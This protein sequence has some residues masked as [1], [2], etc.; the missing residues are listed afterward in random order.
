MSSDGTPDGQLSVVKP[1]AVYKWEIDNFSVDNWETGQEVVSPVIVIN[2]TK[3]M[4][5]L[6][7]KGI[8]E[9]HNKDVSI[10]LRSLNESDVEIKFYFSILDE[11]N[12]M[13]LISGS[14]WEFTQ[15]YED[16]GLYGFIRQALLMKHKYDMLPN[17]KLT[18]LCEIIIIKR[19]LNNEQRN[20]HLIPFTTDAS[21]TNC[22]FS[23]LE[24]F[25]NNELFSDV[26]F[27]ICGKE[28]CAHK[29]M[30]STKSEVFA[31]MF[32]HDMKDNLT[33]TIEVED[34]GYE[35]F[36]EMCRYIYAAKINNM[37]L[38]AEDLYV[39]AD[40]YAL[41]ELTDQCFDCLCEGLSNDNIIERLKF[42]D[43]HSID[44]LKTKA[45]DFLICH[46]KDIVHN[47]EFKAIKELHEDIIVEVF[48]RLAHQE[49]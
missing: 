10:M 2:E 44:K 3:W 7:P 34:I 41:R 42:A 4:I 14:K 23:D 22:H 17:S 18:I 40:K 31:A 32:K 8:N 35:I 20:N 30:L 9:D 21:C 6:Y 45:I 15:K 28:F 1:N 46:L 26:K 11:M 5:A 25:L 36:T 43:I 29:I 33:S 27:I 39:A 13:N 24:D 12:E 49:K 47:P 16:I 19:N 38:I 48:Q 37:E